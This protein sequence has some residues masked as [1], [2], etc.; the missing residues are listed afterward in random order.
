MAAEVGGEHPEV[1]Q[2]LL[3]QAAEA[4]AVA[5]HTVEA[6]DGRGGRVTPLVDVQ[7]HAP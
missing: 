3:G 2:P 4:A 5:H 7:Q 6:E 1:G